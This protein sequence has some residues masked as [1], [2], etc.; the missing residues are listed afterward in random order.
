MSWR[1]NFYRTWCPDDAKTVGHQICRNKI[2]GCE[3]NRKSWSSHHWQSVLEQLCKEASDHE[4]T[5]GSAVE[6]TKKTLNALWPCSIQGYLLQPKHGA[7]PVQMPLSTYLCFALSWGL[8]VVGKQ[9]Q[10]GLSTA[11]H[12]FF[13]NGTQD[14]K[15]YFNWIEVLVG[16]GTLGLLGF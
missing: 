8:N 3:Q 10:L 7:Y 11:S 1:P 16:V 4:F 9:Q 14:H 15:N 2:G 13:L 6:P 12:F 5:S